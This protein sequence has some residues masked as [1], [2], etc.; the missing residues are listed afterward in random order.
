TTRARTDR[1][2]SPP[3]PDP[4]RPDKAPHAT[5]RTLFATLV[6]ESTDDTTLG[7]HPSWWARADRAPRQRWQPTFHGGAHRAGHGVGGG[8][9]ETGL[10]PGLRFRTTRQL[11]GAAAFEGD[12]GQ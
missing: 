10:D 4:R 1:R 8:R 7:P 3:T 6:W 12:P 2:R 5:S 11:C 9:G